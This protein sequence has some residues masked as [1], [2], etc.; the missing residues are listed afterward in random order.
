MALGAL[1]LASVLVKFS[2][3]RQLIYLNICFVFLFFDNSQHCIIP[4]VCQLPVNFSLS[5]NVGLNSH[6]LLF[7]IINPNSK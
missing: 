1:T 7:I 4:V 3:A 6:L 5:F 2:Q